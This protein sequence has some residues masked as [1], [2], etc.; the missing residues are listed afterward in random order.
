MENALDHVERHFF[1]DAARWEGDESGVRILESPNAYAEAERAAAEILR[2][3]RQE[4]WR[5]RDVTVTARSLGAYEDVVETVFERYGI[6]LYSA[7][8]SA[9][10]V[11]GSPICSR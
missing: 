10:S 6:P 2:L 11:S 8:V 9:S 5:W 1:G 3:V 7:R 4:G